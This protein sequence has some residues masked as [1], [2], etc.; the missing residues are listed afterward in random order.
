MSSNRRS[1]PLV[2]VLRA[3]LL[4]GDL[5][6]GL[7]SRASHFTPQADSARVIA[8]ELES[9]LRPVSRTSDRS[10]SPPSCGPSSGG[11]EN[12]LRYRFVPDVKE[13]YNRL[14]ALVEVSMHSTGISTL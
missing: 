4:G 14:L 9:G 13:R 11:L 2:I 7:E 8:A 3:D 12:R 10:P 6:P 1:V 5:S